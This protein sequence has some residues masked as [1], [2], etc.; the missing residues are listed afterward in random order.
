LPKPEVIEPEQPVENPIFNQWHTGNEWYLKDEDMTDFANLHAQKLTKQDPNMS[1]DQVLKKVEQ[2]IKETFPAKFENPN[3]SKPSAVDGG[4]NREIAPK[5]TGKSFNDLDADAKAM[6]IQNVEQGLYK[7]K[8]DW[9]KA[10][11]EE[12]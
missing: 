7:S 2:K 1:Y 6:C 11:F 8:E 12:E 10:Y 9:V 4:T 3:R 5:T